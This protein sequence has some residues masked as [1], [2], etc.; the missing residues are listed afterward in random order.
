MTTVTCPLCSSDQNKKIYA[1]ENAP[2][3]QNK[4]Y[5]SAEEAKSADK[6]VI[7]LYF[8]EKCGFIW[9]HSFE[10]SRL[11]YDS[12]YQNEQSHSKVFMDHLESVKKI[13]EENIPAGSNIVE[14]GCGKGTFLEILRNTGR[15]NICGYDPAYEGESEYVKKCY[16]PPKG[17]YAKADLFVMR[18]VIEHV[19]D[20]LN[21]LKNISIANENSGK[22][23]IEVPDIGWIFNTGAF[24]DI[25]YEHCNY[26]SVPSL[27][28]IIPS[29]DSGYLF[30]DQYIYLIGNFAVNDSKEGNVN[31]IKPDYHSLIKNLTYCREFLE[32]KSNFVV[33]G[34]AAKGA[35]FVRIVDPDRTRINYVVDINPKKQGR[36]L[37]GSGHKI[38]SPKDLKL[39]KNIEGIIVM[40]ENY[41]DEI[42]SMM[43]GWNGDFY[44]LDKLLEKA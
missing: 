36:Y 39:M 25:S 34:A 42:R 11:T 26:F 29:S 41:L 35:N 8:C 20:P 37:G 6:G 5:L 32:D 44:I 14:I 21:F 17:E 3:F 38:I 9:N 10:P 16:Y 40:N 1:D 12:D 30:G 4:T 2:L 24:W 18:H 13:I 15:Y 19:P 43:N 7:H 28:R 22:I 31:I 23:Y 33:W 27:Q